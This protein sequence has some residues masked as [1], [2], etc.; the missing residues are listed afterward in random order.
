MRLPPQSSPIYRDLPTRQ[1]YLKGA[2]IET[3]QSPC[4]SL[5]GMARQMCY[6]LEYGIST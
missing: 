2:G 6:A 4:D 5:Y 1:A 3:S